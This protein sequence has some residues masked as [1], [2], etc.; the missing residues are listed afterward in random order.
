MISL[1]CNILKTISFN[2]MILNAKSKTLPKICTQFMIFKFQE[3]VLSLQLI[4]RMTLKNGFYTS[5]NNDSCRCSS[6]WSITQLNTPIEEVFE[7]SFLFI[8][9]QKF[10]SSWR[11]QV[12]ESLRNISTF[13][14]KCMSLANSILYTQA[15]D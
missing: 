15:K 5:I 2:C 10:K 8:I 11:T 1:T 6:T 4:L 12:R 13:F 7:W 14:L 3:K 9:K